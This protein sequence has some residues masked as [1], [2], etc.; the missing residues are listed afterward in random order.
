MKSL[1]LFIIFA[2]LSL[3]ASS[4]AFQNKTVT[5]SPPSSQK[6]DV[7]HLVADDLSFAKDF[8]QSLSDAGWKIQEVSPSKFN[9]FFADS[10]QA[11]FI[12]TDKGIVEAV[13]FQSKADVE[14]IQVSEEQ[15][16]DLQHHR[17]VVQ[18]L[19]ATNQRIEGGAC[20]F[21][22]YRNAFIITIDRELYDALSHLPA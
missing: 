6:A 10:R 19:P 1:A 16:G 2:A 22:K 9:G 8:V 12:R 4:C 15:T 18:K 5:S 13:F 20:Y 14:Q 21:T 17:Y 3:T 7:S 11:A